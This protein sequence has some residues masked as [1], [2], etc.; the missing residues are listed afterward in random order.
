[1]SLSK[2]EN[3]EIIKKFGRDENDPGSS[4][5]Q[6]ALLTHR[7]NALSNHFAQHKHD[8]HSR[9]GLLKMVS[10]RRKFLAYMKKRD[11]QGYRKL[12]SELGLRF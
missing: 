12:V 3:K 11:L 9:R 10:A 7:I 6:I 4:S 2:E 8:H 5:A 1:M